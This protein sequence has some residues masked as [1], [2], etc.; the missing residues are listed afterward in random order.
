MWIRSRNSK[1]ITLHDPCNLVRHGGIIEE[2][3][4]N[5]SMEHQ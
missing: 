3:R 2:Q 1:R 5:P 4:D